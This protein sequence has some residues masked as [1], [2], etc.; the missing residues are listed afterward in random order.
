MFVIMYTVFTAISVT[1]VL[2]SVRVKVVVLVT[3][4]TFVKTSFESFALYDVTGAVVELVITVEGSAIVKE[5]ENAAFPVT[6]VVVFN[7]VLFTR[8]F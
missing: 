6:V 1:K 4:V 5:G 7:Q 8:T 3:F 2:V